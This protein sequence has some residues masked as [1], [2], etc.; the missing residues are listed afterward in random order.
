MNISDLQVQASR[1]ETITVFGLVVELRTLG[2]SNGMRDVLEREHYSSSLQPRQGRL[3]SR[4]LRAGPLE[5]PEVF[6]LFKLSFVRCTF[7]R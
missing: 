6:C 7:V 3:Q 4:F 1:L 2:S 5:V